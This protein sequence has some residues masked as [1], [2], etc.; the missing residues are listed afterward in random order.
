MAARVDKNKKQLGRLSAVLL[1]MV[2]WMQ[3][4]KAVADQ[5]SVEPSSL[6]A[7]VVAGLLIHT[8]FLGFNLAAVNVLKLGGNASHSKGTSFLFVQWSCSLCILQMATQ[9]LSR[10]LGGIREV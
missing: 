6:A 3:I 5:I 1:A 10:A 9:L 2:P 7:A 4:S 8:V